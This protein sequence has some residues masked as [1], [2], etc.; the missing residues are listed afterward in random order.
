MYNLLMVGS[1]GYWEEREGC[2][3]DA[4][5]YL[6]HTDRALRERLCPLTPAVAEELRLWPALFAYEL[7]WHE[8]VPST[9]VARVGWLTSV[10]DRIAHIRISY[11]FD[12]D[13]PPV[14]AAHIRKIL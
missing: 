13:V 11:K 7:P 9:A 10:D 2:D 5:R 12:R 1:S 4:T 3:F 14:S 6:E 8:D